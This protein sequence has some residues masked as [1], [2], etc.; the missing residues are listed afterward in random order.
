VAISSAFTSIWLVYGAPIIAFSA[1]YLSRRKKHE[2]SA[3]AI[4]DEAIEAGLIEPASLH[5][6][7]DPASCIGC[8]TCV[9]ACPEHTVLGIID[10]KAELV[11]PTNCIGHGACAE[12]CPV[13]AIDLVFGTEKRGVDIP[14]VSPQFETDVAGIFIAGELG[15]MGL[16]RNAITQGCQAM[17]GV[18]NRLATLRKESVPT[19]VI[20]VV[21]VG[22]GP[23]GFAASLAAKEK[24]LSFVTLEQ[25]TFGGTVAHYP[26]G[27]I[28]MTAPVTLPI[29]G[30]VRLTE[31]T[32]EELMSFWQ[33]IRTRTGLEVQ[34]S[35]R[36]TAVG[37]GKGY[38]EVATEKNVY[39]ARTVLLA[40]GRRGTPR[41]LGVAGENLSKVVYR[42]IDPAQYRGLAVLVVGGGD[43]A[44]EAALSIVEEADTTVSISYRGEAF[45]RAKAKNRERLRTA[46]VSGLLKVY[47]NS[48]VSAIGEDEVSLDQGGNPIFL[49]NDAIIVC[50]GGILPTGFLKESGVGVE[51]KYG[52]R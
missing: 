44:L 11:S 27:K 18:I 52:T 51:T 16:I 25:E 45:S 15:G 23:A 13:G 19:G 42:L 43:S 9:N 41:K 14:L 30:K 47:F 3:R 31:T 22:A 35:E 2:N 46:Q 20:D 39:N 12:A 40:I 21:I 37:R 17:D 8:G 4:R 32:K 34:Y 10:G 36:V 5:P 28:V 48:E 7:I 1:F 26:R 6:V 29:V 38:F 24:G 49:R 50:A 33:D